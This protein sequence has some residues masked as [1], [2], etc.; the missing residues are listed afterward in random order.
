LIC[1]FLD[2]NLPKKKEE[3]KT[4]NNL[5]TQQVSTK[6][7]ISYNIPQI[8]HPS[9]IHHL[10]HHYSYSSMSTSRDMPPP[11]SKGRADR[12]R[13]ADIAPDPNANR[14][15]DYPNEWKI[16]HNKQTAKCMICGNSQAGTKWCVT[17]TSCS[18]RMCSPCWKGERYNSYGEA[19]FEGKAQNDEGCWCRFPSKTDQSYQPKF[20]ARNQRTKAAIAAEKAAD[21][22]DAQE[23]GSKYE[24]PA[25]KRQKLEHLSEEEGDQPTRG[26]RSD[27]PQVLQ[28]PD[29]WEPRRRSSAE[30]SVQQDSITALPRETRSN[31]KE[32]HVHHKRT[33]VVGAGVVGLWIAREL[34][35]RTHNTSTHHDI[36]VIEK[37]ATYGLEASNHCAGLITKHGVP[38]VYGPLLGLSL[39]CWNEQLAN[40]DFRKRIYYVPNSIV[41]VEAN[42]EGRSDH[43]ANPPS[44]Y[45]V[46]P[47][48]V[49]KTYGSDVGK[50]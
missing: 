46:Q 8:H 12:H 36:L 21:A 10:H 42:L 47:E 1:S 29:D 32:K 9:P 34:A 28:S 30:D 35:A 11:A 27:Y 40:E 25:A 7:H 24:M 31:L 44:W 13:A 4:D 22:Q 38:E 23:G 17:C 20:E 18:K 48:D 50:M 19:I 15:D 41:H 43:T 33:I 16:E 49:F 39:K 5:T 14:A 3:R 45:N 2:N 26:R 37:R 6:N